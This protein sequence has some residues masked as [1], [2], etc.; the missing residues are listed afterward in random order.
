MYGIRSI[1]ASVTQRNLRK[2]CNFM[3]EIIIC[4]NKVVILRE[5]V[6]MSQYKDVILTNEHMEFIRL[7]SDY[8]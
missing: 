6:M 7:T 1:R 4:Q 2:R 8:N 5:K 3:G